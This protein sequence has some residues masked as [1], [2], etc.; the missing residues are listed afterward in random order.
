MSKPV[1]KYSPIRQAGNTY[2]V[3]G[4]VGFKTGTTELVSNDLKEQTA[5]VMQN[6]IDIL[7][8]VNLALDDVVKTTV[9]LNDISY[10]GPVNEVYAEY[11]T[12]TP[13]AR[14]AFAVGQLPVGAKVEIDAIAYKE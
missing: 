7:A 13:P 6:I 9:Y 1:A 8:T 2:Y 11:I 14:A 12:G 10:Y 3:A 4:Q 5:Q